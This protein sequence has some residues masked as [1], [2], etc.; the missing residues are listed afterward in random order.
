MGHMRRTMNYY[1]GQIELDSIAGHHLRHH[2]RPNGGN[3]GEALVNS[4][5]FVGSMPFLE[6][7]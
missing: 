6:G 4:P 1:T 3:M 2:T 5:I 7:D